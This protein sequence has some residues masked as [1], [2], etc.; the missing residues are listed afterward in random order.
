MMFKHLLTSIAISVGLGSFMYL[1]NGIF[2]TLEVLQSKEII[3][4]WIAS[5]LIGVTF[6]LY[7]T[8][9]SDVLVKVI[10]F[11]VGVTAFTTIAVLNRWIT[12]SF[13]DILSYA[14]I[15]FIIMLI[16]FTTFYL[17]S[18]LDS[19]KINEKLNGK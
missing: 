3:S 12:I 18:F 1:L 6:V 17:I 10:Q 11:G 14:G 13:T 2:G 8:K 15:T 4:V 9:I 7:Y 16:I 5:A 19:K